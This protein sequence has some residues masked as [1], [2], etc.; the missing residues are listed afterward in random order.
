MKKEKTGFWEKVERLAEQIWYGEW[1]DRIY[2]LCLI[3]FCLALIFWC[4]AALARVF[5][6]FT[7]GI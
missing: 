5:L 6:Y 2:N 3:I 4:I 1:S 7:T